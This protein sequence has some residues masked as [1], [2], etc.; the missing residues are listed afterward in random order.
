MPSCQRPQCVTESRLSS[1][2]YSEGRQVSPLDA[3]TAL[4]SVRSRTFGKSGPGVPV[5]T[6]RI[7]SMVR[8]ILVVAETSSLYVSTQPPMTMEV[9][10]SR[11]E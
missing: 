2:R 7:A 4:T 8:Y 10:A 9:L 5:E 11:I 6:P 3:V 1:L